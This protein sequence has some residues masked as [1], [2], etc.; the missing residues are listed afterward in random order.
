[1]IDSTENATPTLSTKTRN[2]NFSVQIQVGARRRGT[3][4]PSCRGA[5]VVGPNEYGEK[6]WGPNSGRNFYC[7]NPCSPNSRIDKPPDR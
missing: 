2:S 4:R 3:P 5:I 7:P 6:N 1:M